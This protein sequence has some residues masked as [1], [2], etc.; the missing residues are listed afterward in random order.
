MGDTTAVD[1]ALSR[2]SDPEARR[3]LRETWPR[4][5]ELYAPQHF[6]LFGSR[7]NGTP[8]EWSDLDAVIVSERFVGTGLVGRA[9]DFKTAVRPHLPMTALCCTPAEFED[10][11]RSVSIVA[12][13]CREGVWVK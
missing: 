10:L 1:D 11:R 12:D 8:H 9:Y 2:L 7:V 3:F 6:I 4:V 13:A 5:Q